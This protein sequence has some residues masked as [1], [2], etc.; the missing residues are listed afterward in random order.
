MKKKIIPVLVITLVFLFMLFIYEPITLYAASTDDYW[1]TFGMLVKSNLTYIAYFSIFLIAIGQIIISISNKLKKEKVYLI[2]LLII[3][4]L[5]IFSYIQGNY[6]S[7]DLPL[8]NGSPIEWNSYTTQM[9]ISIIIFIIVMGVNIFLLIKYKENY[10]KITTYISL[11]IFLML[12]TGLVTT[13]L[14]NRQM[15][16]ERGKNVLTY[17]NINN[18]STDK[19]FLIFLIDMTD[20]RKFEQVIEANNKKDMLKDFSYFP[21]TLSAYPFTRESIPFVLT[22]QWYEGEKDFSLY[23]NEAMN[24]S[25]LINSLVDKE[26]EINLYEDNMFWTDKKSEVVNNITTVE[27]DVDKV[28][29]LGEELKLIGFKYLPFPIKQLSNIES[30]DYGQCKNFFNTKAEMMKHEYETDNK[31]V[32]NALDTINLQENKY[33][34]FIHIYGSHFPWDEN[35]DFEKIEN[36]TY[37]NKIEQAIVVLEKYLNRIKESGQY[38]NSV[39]I[40]MADH[41]GGDYTAFG[42]Q[43]PILYIKGLN[44]THDEM[45]ISDKKVSYVDLSDSIYL[46]LLDEKKS[47]EL[48]P[49][50]EANR[51]R[52]FLWYCVNE[53]YTEQILD[54]HAWEKEKLKNT[55]KTYSRT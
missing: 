34:Q 7:A 43:N 6:L 9:I 29:F 10:K 45:I 17:A 12:S 13:L 37:E 53:P 38:D 31:T 8:L 2:Y 48:L 21:D 30:L 50:L 4:S 18:L 26:Y 54:G 36:G 32:Y 11:A 20:S 40:I 25:V 22:G 44:E 39:I 41:G 14:T 16:K 3:S 35:K 55:G 5:F 52:R 46:D 47:T 24:N 23:Y 49:N 1:F 42:L 15:Y 28:C 33:F 19:N 27:F 51:V